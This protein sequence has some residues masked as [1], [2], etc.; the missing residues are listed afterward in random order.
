MRQQKEQQALFKF[1][2]NSYVA[3]QFVL[4]NLRIRLIFGSKILEFGDFSVFEFGN[5]DE[6]QLTAD[7]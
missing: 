2:L 5:Q 7:N 1:E 6:L 3:I 4:F